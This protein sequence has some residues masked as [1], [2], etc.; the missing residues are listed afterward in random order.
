[1]TLLIA[2]AP[3]R[4]QPVITKVE[5]PNWWRGRKRSTIEILFTGRDLQ[6]LRIETD[7]GITA[8]DVTTS[9]NGHY[10]FVPIDI[11]P[12]ASVG[13]HI[14]AISNRNGGS[15]VAF[16]ID[17]PPARRGRF[18]GLSPEDII[19]LIMPDRFAVGQDGE[20]RMAG[21]GQQTLRAR[22]SPRARHGGNFSGVMEHLPYLKE[23][24]VTAI[25]LTPVYR[26]GRNPKWGEGYHGYWVSDYYDIE[27]GLGTLED[28]S[29]LVEKAHAIGLKVIQD[30]VLNHTSTD[31]AWVADP[32]TAT[33]WNGSSSRHRQNKFNISVL[34][35]RQ[36]NPRERSASLEGW[37]DN[38]PDLRQ[39]DPHVER[40]LI[41]NTLWWVA[42]TGVD[43]I[44]LDAYPFVP[45]PFWSKWQDGLSAEFPK[46]AAIAE[47]TS[48]TPKVVAYFQGGRVGFDGIDTKLQS[49][50]DFP[51]DRTL[52]K[53]L[54]GK[55]PMSELSRVLSDD[56]LYPN[57]SM[58]VTFCGNHD[59]P[60]IANVVGGNLAK[61]KL[62]H[63]LVLASRGIPQLY[64]GDEIG[65]HGGDDPDNR[66]DFPGGFPGDRHSAFD[67]RQRMEAENEILEHWKTWA[68]GR[69]S[70]EALTTGRVITLH[71][72]NDA[73][74]FLRQASRETVL[75]AVSRSPATKQISLRMPKELAGATRL[76][77]LIVDAAAT[78]LE[79]ELAVSLPAFGGAAWR[80]QK[81]E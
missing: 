27:P 17:E 56:R 35:D 20:Q 45:R 69:K 26:N 30:Q 50:F 14:F 46:M 23:L 65:M 29:R 58:L 70:S 61:I 72:D 10:A 5:P 9:A 76:L 67:R 8:H 24:G 15:K 64:A 16:R 25:W 4:G 57:P 55:A 51:F 21:R 1:L 28:Y 34:A 37:F 40:Y 3:A 53:V 13:D 44:R 43:A 33:W 73:W 32:P 18:Q 66:R 38:L 48:E 78:I 75:V 36:G 12:G 39:E 81:S 47:I 6:G 22:S 59:E 71:A 41:Q 54:S 63:T 60:R 52:R 80:I 74:V 68:K 49:A 77:P 79:G 2:L 62:A 42:R 19:Y 31:H 11:Q 7:K